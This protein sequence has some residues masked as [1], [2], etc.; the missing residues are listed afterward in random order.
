M[1][2]TLYIGNLPQSATEQALSAKFGRC[3]TV[4]SVTIEMHPETGRSRGFGYVE[5]GSPVDM[6]TAIHR[7]NFS[8]YDGRLMSVNKST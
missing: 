6:Q 3:G 4:V 5:M 1:S 8:D 2:N 7:L